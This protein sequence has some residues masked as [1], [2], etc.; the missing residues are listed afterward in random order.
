MRNA[1]REPSNSNVIAL[2]LV[3]AVDTPVSESLFWPREMASYL[4]K[5]FISTPQ[6]MNYEHK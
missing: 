2:I 1:K 5:I 6:I 4:V 3:S